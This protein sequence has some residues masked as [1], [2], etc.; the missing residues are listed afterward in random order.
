MRAP[1]KD[2]DRRA[3][4]DAV[5]TTIGR[6]EGDLQRIVEEAAAFAKA[7]IASV[8]MIDRDRQ[9][10]VATVGLDADE[11]RRL[12]S[13]CNR[14][15]LQPGEP[16]V[17]LDAHQQDQYANVPAVTAAPFVRFYVGIS[18]VDRAGYALGTLSVANTA[19]RREAPELTTLKRLARE[20]ERIITNS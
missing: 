4:A 1:R 10:F 20:A 5:R 8:S 17:I 7:P 14:V 15:I 6:R 11:A 9:W 18:L 19:A 13:I 16:L 3:C 2:V 12:D